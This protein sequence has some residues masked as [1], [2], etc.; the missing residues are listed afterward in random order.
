M[1][2]KKITCVSNLAHFKIPIT[3]KVQRTYNIPHISTVSGIIKNIYGEDINNFILGYRME[4]KGIHKEI[5]R[6]Y[7]D[8]N[9]RVKSRTCSERF[10]TDIITIEY[11][12]KPKLTIYTNLSRKFQLNDVLNLGKTDCLATMVT[13]DVKLTK[14]Y[15]KGFNQYTSLNTGEG[16]IR[17]INTQTKYNVEKGYYEYKGALV[18]ENREFEYE[19]YFDEDVEQSIFLWKWNEG[20]IHEFK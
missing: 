15:G 9:T 19:G 18:R 16:M 10:Q 12:I 20:E 4:H 7:K 17:R 2:L 13:E 8:V 3:S 6:V 11:L 5:A 14:N 1:E